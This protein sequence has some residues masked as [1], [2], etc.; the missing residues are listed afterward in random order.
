MFGVYGISLERFVFVFWVNDRRLILIDW[1]MIYFDY[2]EI[3]FLLVNG[4]WGES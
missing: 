4:W 2:W 3:L 1:I